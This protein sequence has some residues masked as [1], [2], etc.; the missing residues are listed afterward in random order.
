M[1]I[2]CTMYVCM[3]GMFITPYMRAL[4]G[5]NAKRASGGTSTDG[6]R[7][8][9]SSINWMEHKHYSARPVHSHEDDGDSSHRFDDTSWRLVARVLC[10]R[11]T[12]STLPSRCPMNFHIIL[13]FSLEIIIVGAPTL[14]LLWVHDVAPHPTSI[15]IARTKLNRSH[16]MLNDKLYYKFRCMERRLNNLIDC[17][18][19]FGWLVYNHFYFSSSSSGVG[20]AHEYCSPVLVV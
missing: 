14:L 8:A 7:F 5:A 13:F 1:S 9:C 3:V 10:A 11:A 16:E 18:V 4:D 17:E 12:D 15:L 19:C 20:G 2:G 6:R